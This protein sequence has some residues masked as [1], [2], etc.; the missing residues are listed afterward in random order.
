MILA[1]VRLYTWVDVEEVLL[2]LQREGKWPGWL[3]SARAYWDGLILTIRSGERDHAIDWLASRFEPRFNAEGPCI[4]LESIRD[5]QRQLDVVFEETEE[6]IDGSVPSLFRPTF[7]RPAVIWPTGEPEHPSS[8]SETLPS[9]IAFHSFK[10]GV[11]RTLHALALASSLTKSNQKVLLV[12]GDLEAPGLSLL[13]LNRF[14]NPAVSLMDFLAL[15]HGDPDP[16]AK[17]SIQLVADRLRDTLLD[18]IHVLPSFRSLSQF[19]SLEIRPEYLIQGAK[20]PFI[21]TTLLA[22]LG[23][24]LNTQAVI[25]DLRAGLSELSAGLL[26]DPRVYRV[27]VTTLSSQSINGTCQLLK[28]LGQLAPSKTDEE[29]LPALII[30]QI[31]KD[32]LW[33]DKQERLFDAAQDLQ[34]GESEQGEDIL[35]VETDFD[36]NLLVIPDS[37][38]EALKRLKQSALFERM[39][40][41]KGWLPSTPSG[42]G[43]T[44]IS[45]ADIKHKR[46]E[47]SEFAESL[48]FAER[49]GIHDF[50]TI[51]PLR[52]L[53]SDFS[54][55]VPIAVIVGAKGAG[56]TYI[57]LQVVRRKNWRRFAQDAGI[58]GPPSNALVCPILQSEN[59]SEQVNKMVQETRQ[60]TTKTLGLQ[61][62]YASPRVKDYVLDRLKEDLHVGEWREIWLNIIAWSAGFEVDS[63][64]AGQSFAAY[65][66]EQRQSIVAV[67]DGLED[68]FQK[69]V[70]RES[71]QTALRA[72]LR[73]VPGWLEQQPYR[74]I[75]LLAF[76]RQDMVRDAVRQNSAQLMDKYRPYALKWNSEEALRL[77]AWVTQKAGVLD[78]PR[79]ARLQSPSKEELVNELVPLWGRKLG[80]ERSREGRS[81]EWIVLA[82]SD[83]KG[84]IQARD[85]VR[86]LHEA[87]KASI[88]DT[89]WKD[90]LLVPTAIRTAIGECS[91]TKIEE[92]Q[93]ENPVLG[94][95]FTRLTGLQDDKKQIPFTREQVSLDIDD[96]KILEDNGVVLREGEEYYMPEIFRLGLGFTLKTGKRPRVLSLTLA[97][98]AQKGG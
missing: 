72:L 86:L 97:R 38:N 9:V 63:D 43:G 36:Q 39:N 74:S 15:A 67:I 55:R 48:I 11:G 81:A 12:D 49:A 78:N 41:L 56:K 13:L 58:T 33:E 23:Q 70:S 98:R 82:L 37:W 22:K 66:H 89:Y 57:F 24:A 2:R 42:D 59:L 26:L 32:F 4:I 80:S 51:T 35:I 68:I 84:Q 88:R 16:E 30:S 85:L 5:Q 17:G 40:I 96:L 93:S 79:E 31:P 18:G 95:V 10:G 25:V 46:G 52:N 60:E 34:K 71:E 76:V 20:D 62:Q 44:K 8:L 29:P 73:E 92:I 75:G 21:L 87:A 94:G 69:L 50:L 3:I 83:Y 6:T 53:A 77:V 61:A 65:L 19:S 64:D 45:E 28:L 7:A 27:L 54:S 1:D 47:L 14:P 90:R 91:K